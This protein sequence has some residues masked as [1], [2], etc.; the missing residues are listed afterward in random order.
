[1]F[2]SN[3]ASILQIKSVE[4]SRLPSITELLDEYRKLNERCDRVLEKMAKRDQKVNE[5]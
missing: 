1:M 3:T 5:E 2:K 4:S